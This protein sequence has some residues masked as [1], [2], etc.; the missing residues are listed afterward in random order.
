[1]H[2]WH[3]DS[4]LPPQ[5]YSCE[6]QTALGLVCIDTDSEA[7]D[8][9]DCGDPPR[10]FHGT[11]FKRLISILQGGLTAGP[12]GHSFNGMR[13]WSALVRHLWLAYS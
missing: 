13:R 12:N 2:L 7:F 11:P 8:L 3:P 10:T 9:K 5:W 1:M 4:V 6:A